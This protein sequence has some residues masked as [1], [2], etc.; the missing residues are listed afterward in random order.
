M[1]RKQTRTEKFKEYREEI[2]QSSLS[3]VSEE[4]SS[5]KQEK[6][7]VVSKHENKPILSATPKAQTKH[8]YDKKEEK[9]LEKTVYDIYAS[10]RRLKRFLYFIFVVIVIG[11]LI[12]LF[13]VLANKFSGLT[14]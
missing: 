11:C 2:K 9:A 13:I 12:A 10:K 5:E 6:N 1:K 14:L 7:N 3:L 4:K 8:A